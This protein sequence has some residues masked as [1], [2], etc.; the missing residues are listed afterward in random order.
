MNIFLISLV[1]SLNLYFLKDSPNLLVRLVPEENPEQLTL[2]YSFATGK[3][4]SMDTRFY[5]THFDAVIAPPESANIIGFYF[6][7]NERIDDNQGMLYLYEIKRSPRMILPFSLDY[8][9]TVIRQARKKISSQ[10]HIDE[11]ITI[12][13]YAEKILKDLPYKKGSEQEIKINLLSSEINELRTL[14][15]K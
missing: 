8:L 6:K 4:D 12:I 13:D 11:A 10:T 9:E 5:T 1:A 15:G 14:V 3:W 7:Y 2:Y